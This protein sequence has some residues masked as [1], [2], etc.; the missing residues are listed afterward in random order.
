M[1]T[2]TLFSNTSV[3]PSFRR[4]LASNT[5]VLIAIFVNLFLKVKRSLTCRSPMETFICPANNPRAEGLECAKTCQN[6]DLECISHGCISG[7]LCPKGMVSR[8]NCATGKQTF[9]LLPSLFPIDSLLADWKY[10][11]MKHSTVTLWFMAGLKYISIR[12]GA[13]SF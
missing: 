13:H 10:V 7:C 8:L 1:C 4:I 11:V 6:Y 3:Y 2:Q 12:T 5:S 9:F